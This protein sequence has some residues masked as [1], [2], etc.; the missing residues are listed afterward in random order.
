MLT[1]ELQQNI[2]MLFTEKAVAEI[3]GNLP[4]EPAGSSL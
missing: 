1:T 3:L 4:R 2:V